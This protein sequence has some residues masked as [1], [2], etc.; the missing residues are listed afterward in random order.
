MYRIPIANWN[1][2]E[3]LVFFVLECASAETFRQCDE[4]QSRAWIV[5][6]ERLFLFLHVTYDECNS[7]LDSSKRSQWRGEFCIGLHHSRQRAIHFQIF[8]YSF[9][10]II[11]RQILFEIG[12]WIW[13]KSRKMWQKI[14]SW[15]LYE[16]RATIIFIILKLAP[17]AQIR[18]DTFLVLFD[19]I[20]FSRVWY[21][22]TC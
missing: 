4:I 18:T 5:V 17:Q 13:N 9:F 8:L 15:I 14:I 16:F 20:C 12:N 19:N 10:F 21:V 2:S 1:C 22:I 7:V 11:I 6:I 3:S